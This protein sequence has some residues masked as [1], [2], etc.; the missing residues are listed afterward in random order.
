MEIRQI[1][2]LSR[3]L[4]VR[5]GPW[6]LAAVLLAPGSSP[7]LAAGGAEPTQECAAPEDVVI[8]RTDER[9]RRLFVITTAEGVAEREEAERLLT[10]LA[11]HLA[12]CHPAWRERWSISFFSDSRFA[13]YKDEPDILP[14]VKDGTWRHGYLAEY[15]H[16]TGALVLYPLL[17]DRRLEMAMR[18]DDPPP[19]PGLR[20]P[21]CTSSWRTPRFEPRGSG[22]PAWPTPGRSRSSP[23]R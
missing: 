15:S 1:Q 16:R 12:R 6:L 7:L 10:R 3:W 4:N 20:R 23:W 9:N 17:P 5:P 13:G 18:I 11:E 14:R 19:P 21:R 22:A 2:S 8:A